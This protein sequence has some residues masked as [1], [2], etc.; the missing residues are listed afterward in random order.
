MEITKD[1]DADRSVNAAVD[2]SV[3][4]RINVVPDRNPEQLLQR[5]LRIAVR[6][7]HL[8]VFRTMTGTE[9]ETAGEIADVMIK[10]KKRG[11]LAVKPGTP[12]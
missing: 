12:F 9:I 3:S 4:G 10:Q 6:R 1:V 7:D 8:T 5:R 2:V 11:R